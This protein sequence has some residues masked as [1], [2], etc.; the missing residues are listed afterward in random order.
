MRQIVESLWHGDAAPAAVAR[1][2][3][4]P[5]SVVYRVITV[6]RN[7]LYDRGLLPIA[8]T[9]IPVVSIGNLAVGGTGKTPFAAWLVHAFRERGARP[10][11]VLRGYGGDEPRVHA[12]LNPDVPVFVNADRGRGVQDAASGGCDL[13]VLDDAFQHRRV[14]RLEDVVLVSAERWREPI[15]LLPSGPWRE[16][17]SALSRASLVIV[18]RKAAGREP[19]ASLMRR[20]SAYTRT[21]AGSVAA[22]QLDSLHHVVTGTMHPLSMISGR[23]VLAVA[24]VGDP[25]SFA[26]QLRQVGARVTLRPYPDHHAFD[27]SDVARLAKDAGTFEHILCTLKDAVKLGPRWPREAPPLWYVS[28]R[29]EVEVGGAEVS[30]LIDR[31]LAARH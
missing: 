15:R 18:T 21:G 11:L 1:A 6:A 12:L 24:G 8:R 9:P 29:C 13:A 4:A 25:T 17:P 20:L 10:A 30:A 5:A 2:V 3:L 7:G 22:L 16:A 31:V 19:A 28:L 27:A 26:G 23:N 14:A